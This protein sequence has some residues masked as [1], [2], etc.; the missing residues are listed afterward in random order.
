LRPDVSVVVVAY[1]CRDALR[2]CLSSIYG[3]SGEQSLEVV[4][5]DN[6]SQDGTPEMVR[7]DFPAAR[8]VALPEN[9]GFAAGVNVGA[10][11]AQGEYLMLLNPDTV[12]HPGSV[13]R[14]VEFARQ[15]PEYGIYGGKTLWPDGSTCPGSCWGKPSLW[16]LFCFATMLSTMFKGSA[17]FDPESLG[18]WRRDSVREVDIVTGCLLLVRRDVWHDLG[19]FD[20]RFFM[21][22]EDADLSLRASVQGLR[23]AITPECV[24]THEVGVSSSR[25]SDK[26]ILLYT[27]KATLLRKHWRVGKREA[28]LALLVAGVGARALT[29]S[30]LRLNGQHAQWMPVWKARRDWVKGY[31]GDGARSQSRTTA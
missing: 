20:T 27:G 3:G 2:E 30:A 29:A 6:A 14:L 12:V 1:H 25:R 23:P 7:A 11:E 16:S 26:L 13:E 10:A 31:P 17:V 8:L 9:V 21:Y 24:V 4:V 5:V 15:H 19:G 28:G 22:G 18:S